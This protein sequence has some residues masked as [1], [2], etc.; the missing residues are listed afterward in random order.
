MRVSASLLEMWMTCSLKAKFRYIDHYP[1]KRTSYMVFG[2]VCHAALEHYNEHG[3]IKAAL[4]LFEELWDDPSKINVEIE[5]WPKGTTMGGM[6]ERGMELLKSYHEK[7]RWDPKT[8]I[9]QEHKFLVPMGVHELTGV[10][11]L[12]EIRKSGRGKE[13]LRVVDYKTSK[14]QP[15]SK[16]TLRLNTQFTAY[17]FAT[18]QKE[19]WLGNGP[20]YPPIA[21]NA[22]ELWERVQG[23][24]RRNIWYHLNTGKEIDAGQREDADYL[25]MYRAVTE[26]ARAVEY[27]VYVPDISADNCLYCDFQKPCGVEIKREYDDNDENFF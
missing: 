26:I 11:D 24:P 2:I 21:P 8:I 17:S 7:E 5:I 13:V 6:R 15:P 1:T 14:R 4:K 18:L 19:F 22:E 27:E 3:D 16:D 9:A 20:D 12:L 10:V 25:R 23:L